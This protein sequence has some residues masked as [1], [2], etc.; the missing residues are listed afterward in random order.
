[1]DAEI[2]K[3]LKTVAGELVKRLG[4]E[5]KNINTVYLKLFEFAGRGATNSKERKYIIKKRNVTKTIDNVLVKENGTQS[6]MNKFV[7]YIFDQTENKQEVPSIGIWLRGQICLIEEQHEIRESALAA[8]DRVSSKPQSGESLNTSSSQQISLHDQPKTSCTDKDIDIVV[9]QKTIPI[10][11][12]VPD[13]K[14]SPGNVVHQ[15][16][17]KSAI[18]INNNSAVTSSQNVQ[19]DN[20]LEQLG[21][22]DPL[23]KSAEVLGINHQPLCHSHDTSI[24]VVPM[25]LVSVVELTYLF[26]KL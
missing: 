14:N 16:K 15:Q 18:I 10:D 20:I 12:L 6:E 11:G 19:F 5:E 23:A 17:M 26:G 1:M 22:L 4:I 21:Q 2:N 9:V 3:L 24:D 25:E 13:I 8:L 7:E